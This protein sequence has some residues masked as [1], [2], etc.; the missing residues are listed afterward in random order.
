MAPLDRRSYIYAVEQGASVG[1]LQHG[2]LPLGIMCFRPHRGGRIGQRD[3]ADHPPVEQMPDRGE[4]LL[5]DRAESVCACISRHGQCAAVAHRLVAALR[6]LR[7]RSGTS[8]PRFCRLS[9][10]VVRMES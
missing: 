3:L 10:G 4:P 2:N 8:R 1:W 6:I 9:D 7:T 5:D